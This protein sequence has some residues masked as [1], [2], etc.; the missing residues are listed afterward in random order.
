MATAEFHNLW[1]TGHTYI[2]TYTHIHKRCAALFSLRQQAATPAKRGITVFC[3]AMQRKWR[4]KFCVGAAHPFFSLS[5]TLLLFLSRSASVYAQLYISMYVCVYVVGCMLFIFACMYVSVP[6]YVCPYVR[7]E[8]ELGV[9]SLYVWVSVC[10]CV[11]IAKISLGNSH[12]RR[13]HLVFFLLRGRRACCVCHFSSC[14]SCSCSSAV[15]RV[16][17]VRINVVAGP[18]RFHL[19]L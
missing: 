6:A 19:P 15:A 8:A 1:D 4:A 10:L 5:L 11:C 12:E 13:H 17:A 16:S 9:C 7:I 3:W 14:V 2:Y 18:L